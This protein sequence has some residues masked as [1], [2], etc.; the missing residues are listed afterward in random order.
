M[1]Y[2]KLRIF[3]NVSMIEILENAERK[4]RKGETAGGDDNEN[5]YWD[6]L[7]LYVKGRFRNGDVVYMK[8]LSGM[9]IGV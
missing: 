9:E 2:S 6:R 3:S 8:Y 7:G 4:R 1:W 5:K